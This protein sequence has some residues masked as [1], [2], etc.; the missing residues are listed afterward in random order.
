M[1]K[2]RQDEN[3]KTDYTSTTLY[4]YHLAWNWNIPTGSNHAPA[5]VER[6][7]SL[8][9]ATSD[10]SPCQ[11]AQIQGIFTLIIH[12]RNLKIIVENLIP[13]VLLSTIC[14]YVPKS[15]SWILL[16]S[17]SQPLPT[18]S[19]TIQNLSYG[20]SNTLIKLS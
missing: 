4:R 13:H 15:N 3:A 17:L 14:A 2:T 18:S 19:T 6:L 10:R 9:K 16:I 12:A 1:E 20:S 8:D 5:R 7:S 11:V